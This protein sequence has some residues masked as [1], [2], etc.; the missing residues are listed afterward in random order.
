MADSASSFFGGG[1]VEA[2]ISGTAVAPHPLLAGIILVAIVAA[3]LLTKT[4]TKIAKYIPAQ[5]ISG[6]LFTLGAFAVFAADAPEALKLDPIVGSVVII[7][8][9]FSD[10]FIGMVCGVVLKY[11]LKLTGA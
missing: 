7:V 1:P 5:T 2:I 11:V 8:T 9:S 3:I 10:P 6:F 4:I